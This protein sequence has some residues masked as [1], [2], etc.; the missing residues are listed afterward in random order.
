MPP[1]DKSSG[2]R[3]SLDHAIKLTRRY[4]E[5]AGPHAER[6][7]YFPRS[8]IEEII[9][10]P[11]C[12]GLRIYHGRHEDGKAAMV[13]VGVRRKR[14]T[15]TATTQVLATPMATNDDDEDLGDMTDGVLGDNHQSC[16]PYCDPTSPLES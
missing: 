3:I 14:S 10:Q 2:H 9:T 8:I 15:T 4:R 16:P 5:H 6:A 1:T 12:I 7:G 11:E 13:L